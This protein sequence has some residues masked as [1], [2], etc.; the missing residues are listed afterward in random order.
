M[1]IKNQKILKETKKIVIKNFLLPTINTFVTQYPE[2]IPHWLLVQGFFGSLFDLQQERINIFI[3]YIKKNKETFTKE[4]VENLDFKDGFVI[5]FQEYIKQ[6]NENKR[7]IMQE[8]FLGFTKFKNKPNFQ[9]ERMYDILNK[10]SDYHIYLIKRLEKED[11]IVIKGAEREASAYEDL[12]Y[13]EYMGIVT[14]EN[15]KRVTT[16]IDQGHADSEIEAD[17]D[18]EEKD[19]FYFSVFGIGFV[20]FIKK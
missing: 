2:F 12:K 9:L 15:E 7:K 20:E 10:L 16:D 13:L 3:E 6:R 4:V 5:T 11:T 8:I 17:S 19:I 18:I 1:G 14:S